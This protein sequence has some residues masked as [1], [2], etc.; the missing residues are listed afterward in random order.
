MNK[1][2]FVPSSC[3]LETAAG[4]WSWFFSVE[5]ISSMWRALKLLRHLEFL[6]R[7]VT[8]FMIKFGIFHTVFSELLSWIKSSVVL[9]DL[10]VA[11]SLY[12]N[13]FNIYGEMKHNIYACGTFCRSFT[14]WG[15]LAPAEVWWSA[16]HSSFISFLNVNFLSFL[17]WF[18]LLSCASFIL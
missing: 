12:M 10:D 4:S 5:L 3:R 17:I 18:R 15:K 7:S 13:E 11:R 1:I 8:K 14:A 16:D 2:M 9:P 6:S